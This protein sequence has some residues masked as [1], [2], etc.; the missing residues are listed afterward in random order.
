MLQL[1]SFF[2]LGARWGCGQGHALAVLSCERDS[3]PIAQQ[4][5]LFPRSVWTGAEIIGPQRFGR[6]TVHF[7]VSRYT[8]EK[9]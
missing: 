5:V 6:R 9:Y 8:V 7:A 3:V 4:S 1:H 2:N